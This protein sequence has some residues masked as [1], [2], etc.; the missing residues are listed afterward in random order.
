MVAVDGKEEDVSERMLGR[1]LDGR[2]SAIATASET[3]SSDSSTMA[4]AA[5]IVSASPSPSSRDAS[6]N[7]KTTTKKKKQKQHPPVVRKTVAAKNKH[8]KPNHHANTGTRRAVTRSAG[9]SVELLSG[10][11]EI[12]LPPKPPK[13]TSNKK[14]SS[15]DN[16][17][18]KVKMLTGTL[19][20]YRNG[21][22]RS[23]KFVRTK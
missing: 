8:I 17:V 23:V 6:L 22:H 12:V 10:I 14:A 7:K 19:Y 21:P 15:S 1:V 3:S 9:P 4:A 2:T 5:A 16:N 18:I 20:M 13:P 11:D